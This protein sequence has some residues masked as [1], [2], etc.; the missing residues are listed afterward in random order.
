MS[1][2]LFVLGW[3]TY[4]TFGLVMV[5]IGVFCWNL[6]L[7]VLFPVIPEITYWKLY[8]LWFLS[9]LLVHGGLNISSHKN[10]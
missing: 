1:R 2:L 8:G 9:S 7:V 6:S 4:L 10:E 5:W 3:L